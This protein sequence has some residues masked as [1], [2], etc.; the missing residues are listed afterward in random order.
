MI[1]LILT[2]LAVFVALVINEWWWRG[3]THG[4]ISRKAVHITVGT[5]VA[6]WPLFLEWRQIELLSLAFV[7]V[8]ALSQRLQLF[9]AIHSVQRPTWGELFF[10]LSVGLVAFAT[11]TPAIYAVALL[12]MSLADG[13]AAITGVKY[14]ASN[15]YLVFGARKS[16]VGSVT[17]ALVST[18]IMIGFALQQHTGFHPSYVL[19]IL[20]ATLL[21]N[22]AIRG[23]DNLLI[24]LLIAFILSRL[25]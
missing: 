24:P 15:A 21:E 6:F 18:A 2:I 23:L 16:I 25:V 14:G 20:A 7:V 12:H 8:V 11:H 5:F 9:R 19:L 13:M 3:R 22:V 17:F 1:S 10:G 4:E